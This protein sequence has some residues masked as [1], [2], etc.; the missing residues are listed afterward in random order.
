MPTSDIFISIVRVAVWIAVA[1]TT[2][3]ALFGNYV[4]L[5]HG[6]K[7]STTLVISSIFILGFLIF[8]A[9]TLATVKNL[10]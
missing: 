6:A 2:F 9:N 4:L 5:K 7:R 3:F 1:I 10:S 8:L